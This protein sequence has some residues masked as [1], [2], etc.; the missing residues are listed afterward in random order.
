M[1][2][3]SAFATLLSINFLPTKK[4]A[5]SIMVLVELQSSPTQAIHL[6]EFLTLLPHC[7]DAP[8]FCFREHHHLRAAVPAAEAGEWLHH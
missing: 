2:V 8:G 4:M 6:R 5:E 3:N 7:F 1:L